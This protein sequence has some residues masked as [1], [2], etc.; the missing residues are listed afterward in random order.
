MNIQNILDLEEDLQALGLEKMGYSLARRICFGLSQF[1]LHKEIKKDTVSLGIRLFFE[2]DKKENKYSL[3]YYDAAYHQHDA[4]HGSINGIDIIALDRRM[5]NVD[6]KKASE[7]EEEAEEPPVTGDL[8]IEQ[9]IEAIVKDLKLLE[10]TVEGKAMAVSLQL[11]YWPESLCKRMQKSPAAFKNRAEVTQRFYVLKGQKTISIDE[12]Y[13]YLQ[14]K[15]LEKQ[16][17]L[18]KKEESEAARTIKDHLSESA[19]GPLQKSHSKK[20]RKAKTE[21]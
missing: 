16:M 4:F 1:C 7:F 17:L 2:K 8:E 9:K 5:A 15:W 21:K 14:N 13:R 10:T 3:L 12:A 20:Y 6:W 18:T 19:N 11:K